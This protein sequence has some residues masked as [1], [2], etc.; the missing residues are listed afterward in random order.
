MAGYGF[1]VKVSALF[2]YLSLQSIQLRF[3]NHNCNVQRAEEKGYMA[4]LYE[5]AH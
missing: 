2:L 3:D 1:N 5:F 4:F